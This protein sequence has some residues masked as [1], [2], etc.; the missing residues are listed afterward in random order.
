M[1]YRFQQPLLFQRAHAK[2]D[3]FEY[4]NSLG[5]TIRSPKHDL[6][7]DLVGGATN[8]HRNVGATHTFICETSKW[9]WKNY[10]GDWLDSLNNPQGSS[11]WASS[12]IPQSPTGGM[13]QFNVTTAMQKIQQEN[14]WVA[15]L[16][17]TISGYGSMQ[18]YGVL[19]DLGKP[20]PSLFVTYED[21]TSEY[22]ECWYT[23]S[24]QTSSAY[25]N[26]HEDKIPCGGALPASTIH[27]LLEFKKGTLGQSVVSATLT[28]PYASS[29]GPL[30]MG[31]FIVWPEKPSTAPE[32][33]VAAQSAFDSDV[34][35]DP[36]VLIRQLV[37][38][39]TTIDNVLDTVRSGS[40]GA[41]YNPGGPLITGQRTEYQFDS[42]LWGGPV[43]ADV[44][45]KLPDRNYDP[46]NKTQKWVG[47]TH[48]EAYDGTQPPITARPTFSVVPSTYSGHGFVP[49]APGLGAIHL[50]MPG[51]GNKPG[52]MWR[53]DA[54]TATD[55]DLWL[56]RSH[57]GRVRRLR[58]RFYTL[59]GSGW[60]AG[61]HQSVMNFN[62]S[63]SGKYPE[64]MGFTTPE[65]L[66]LLEA[67][68]SDNAGKFFGGGQHMTNSVWVEGYKYATRMNAGVPDDTKVAYRITSGYGT[69]SGGQA[70]YQGRM[71][72]AGGFH[73]PIGGPAEGGMVLGM[74][75]YDQQGN[76]TLPPSL[77]TI[78]SWDSNGKSTF[79]MNGGLG[80]IYPDGFWRCVELEWFLNPNAPYTLPPAGTNWNESGFNKPPTGY[81]KCWIDGILAHATPTFGF[82]R[83]PKIDWALQAAKGNPLGTLQSHPQALRPVTNVTDEEYLGFASIIGNLYYGGRSP[84]PVDKHLFINGIV[85]AVDD[86]YIGP[87]LGVPRIHGGA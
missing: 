82:T 50:K 73:K 58:Y 69:G 59:L 62:G 25:I 6:R 26:A 27:G 83:L 44:A 46:V 68:P 39:Y 10:K 85:V 61:D 48:S 9:P 38:D 56:P 11:P 86:C 21:G 7:Y 63:V 12:V 70:G 79:G 66:A 20:A 14:H 36:R 65:Q 81:I 37:T 42:S 22:L 52:Q 57:M 29:T 87:M 23:G 45:N 72:W 1:K 64:E 47:T 15:F 17:R 76:V 4:V 34:A 30:T 55:L 84:C 5:Q 13:V 16:L 8:C 54:E 18:F 74:H 19:N 77:A 67:R 78:A 53:V 51:R 2:F 32:L 40:G 75:L 43:P 33:G 49:L 60:E 24:T 3:K 31:V 28:V 41:P 71:R 35:L 80:H